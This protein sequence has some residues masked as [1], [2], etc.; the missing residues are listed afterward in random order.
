MNVIKELFSRYNVYYDKKYNMIIV[1]KAINVKDFILLK[2][3]V[4]ELYWYAD[5]IRV[6]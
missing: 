1:R 2:Q 6:Y 3:I 4:K 5:D